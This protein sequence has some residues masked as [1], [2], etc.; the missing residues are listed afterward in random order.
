M[1]H[2]GPFGQARVAPRC[3]HRKRHA[4][5]PAGRCAPPKAGCFRALASLPAFSDVPASQRDGRLASTRNHLGQMVPIYL[6][7]L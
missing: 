4:T 6:E 2:I 3:Q 7:P 1:G 5:P